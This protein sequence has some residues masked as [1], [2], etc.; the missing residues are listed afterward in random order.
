MVGI[1][2]NQKLIIYGNY[3]CR[4]IYPLM[5]MTSANIIE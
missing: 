4:I 3:I 2:E 5:R 1:A